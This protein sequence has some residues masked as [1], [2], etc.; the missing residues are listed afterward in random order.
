MTTLPVVTF[1]ALAGLGVWLLVASFAGW[2]VLPARPVRPQW[3][4]RARVGVPPIRFAVAV[5]VAGGLA[6]LVVTGW[7]SATVAVAVGVVLFW[8][9][10]GSKAMSG[11]LTARSEAVAT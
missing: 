10:F 11:Q 3:S 4:L 8:G 9:R 2:P 7:P 5:A 1:G 6:V